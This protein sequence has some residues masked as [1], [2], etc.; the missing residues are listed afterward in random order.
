MSLSCLRYFL[1]SDSPFISSHL[2]WLLTDTTRETLT[3]PA[4][5]NIMTTLSRWRTSV[6]RQNWRLPAQTKWLKKNQAES[7]VHE[8]KVFGFLIG[9]WGFISHQNH[10]QFWNKEIR[11]KTFL[12]KT[13]LTAPEMAEFLSQLLLFCNLIDI[14]QSEVIVCST[15]T[16]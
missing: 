9:C 7:W 10:H 3:S 12:C 15:Q 5:E 1:A 8:S 4:S 14:W 6:S 16:R 13:S 11:T 2:F